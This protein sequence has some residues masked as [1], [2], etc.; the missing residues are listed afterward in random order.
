MVAT[1]DGITMADRRLVRLVVTC[2]A[3]C[4]ITA[5]LVA[6]PPTSA[7]LLA[8]RGAGSSRFLRCVE[9]LHSQAISR[10]LAHYNHRRGG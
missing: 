3:V 4:A 2:S 10:R 5:P 9:L 1:A 8:G 7:A 6:G